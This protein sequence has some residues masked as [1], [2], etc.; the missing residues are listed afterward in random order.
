MNERPRRP[1]ARRAQ[2]ILGIAAI[3]WIVLLVAGAIV[4]HAVGHSTASIWVGLL[5]AWILGLVLAGG[6][7]FFDRKAMLKRMHPNEDID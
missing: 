1:G 5:F 3:I 6:L 2:K 7:I 4:G